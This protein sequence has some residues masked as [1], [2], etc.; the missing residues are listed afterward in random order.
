MDNDFC[1]PQQPIPQKRPA[2]MPVSPTSEQSAVI[3]ATATDSASLMIRAYAGAAK[4]TT[5]RLAAPGV[6]TPALALAF[7]R[8]I[9]D[10]LEPA[11]PPHFT[12]KTLNG[13]GHG[14]WARAIGRGKLTLDDRKIPKLI[15]QYSDNYRL[16]LSTAQWDWLRSAVRQAQQVGLTP[17]NEGSPM[18]PD[19]PESWTEILDNLDIPSP[20]QEFITQAARDILAESNRLSRVGTISF[21]DQVYCPTVLGGRWTQYPV[22][23]I[24]ESQDLSPLNHQMLALSLRLGGR[25]VAVGDPKQAIYAFRGADS[26]SMDSMRHLSGAWSDLSLSTTFRCPKVIVDRQQSHAPGFNAWEGCANG[27][28]N[29][30]LQDSPDESEYWTHEYLEDHLDYSPALPYPLQSLAILCRN[31]APLL[32]LAF[33][34]LRQNIGCYMLGRDIG[35][36]LA[37]L[38]TR[39][40]PSE[41]TPITAHLAAVQDYSDREAALALANDKPAKADRIR[42]QSESLFAVA[43]G[44]GAATSGD[45]RN[46]LG[47][48]FSRDSGQ[49]VL[50][51]IHR[52]KGMEWDIVVH[53]DPWRCPAKR[54]RKDPIQWEQE[55]NLL[56]VC[57]TRTRHTLLNLNLADFR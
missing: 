2:A 41:S 45:L 11:L 34:L 30:P 37:A 57:E 47:K 22:V 26:E 21:N 33:K 49:I 17:S 32:S 53:L 46:A 29:G 48:L 40:S 54:A 28:I 9:A 43:E 24:D 18:T 25:L 4:P 14:A 15:K 19:T 27:H 8:K 42:D 16:R 3:D 51:T 5:L 10:E 38:S 44:T 52:A 6:R 13:L 12:T 20:E 36:G 55:K 35:R 23:F 56:Y 31:N 1:Q 39:L 50:S 7:N